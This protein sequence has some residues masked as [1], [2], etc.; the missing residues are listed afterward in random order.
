MSRREFQRLFLTGVGG[1]LTLPASIPGTTVSGGKGSQG[2]GASGRAG[3]Q[4]PLRIDGD[5]LNGTLR[6]LGEF[7]ANPEGGVSRVAYSDADREARAYVEELLGEAGLE[8]SLDLAGNLIGRRAG[9]E[10]R[11][12]P[13]GTGSHI[14]SVPMGGNY[15]GQVGSMAA[16]EV[17]RTLHD[18]GVTTRHPLEVLVFQNEEG[19]KTGSRALAGE[20]L[21]MELDLETRSGKTIGEGIRFLGG[22]PDR[23]AEARRAPGSMAAFVELHVEQGAVL[24]R[25]GTQ[26][27]VV[28]GIVGIKRWR[29]TV[30]GFANHA[31]TTPMD[32]RRDAMLAAARFVQ[33]VNDV[34]R[35]EP[36]TQVGTV[37]QI[38]AFPGAPN[39]IPGRVVVSL[40]I[41]DLAMGR[42][43]ALFDRIAER[44][45]A[46]GHET[47]TSFAL[48]QFYESRAAP[49]DER[50]R[51]QIVQAA[52]DLGL[53]WRSMPSGAGHDA[54]SVAR[55]APIGMIFVPSVEGI[56]HSP[57]EFTRPE[58]VERG[59]NVL[60]HTLLG[61]D[62]TLDR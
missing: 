19:G 14:D 17:A 1:A 38:E 40:E 42:I 49:T 9:S 51:R 4:A 31:G 45:S 41:R 23:L 54:Q 47:G 25:T 16:I 28:E 57:R 26:I 36:G 20:V 37:G 13:L 27:G 62:A 21:P 2:D 60:L 30:T 29:V 3:R 24:D 43:D 15:D 50:L 8:P 48:D 59:A 39:V 10:P 12:R 5:R 53:S 35:S 52:E 58:D 46:I 55:F 32:Q 33:A 11:L 34:I 56:S 7:A 18:H 22:E 61:L 6:R 44:A